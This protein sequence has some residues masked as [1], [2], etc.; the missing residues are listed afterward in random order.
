MHRSVGTTHT[1]PT[2]QSLQ[3]LI[4]T[5]LLG[6]HTN[7]RHEAVLVCSQGGQ[8]SDV[9]LAPSLLID[10]WHATAGPSRLINQW[11]VTAA[12]AGAHYARS[13]SPQRCT[14]YTGVIT[15]RNQVMNM[16]DLSDCIKPSRIL[17]NHSRQCHDIDTSFNQ[18][19]KT[20]NQ[21][22]QWVIQDQAAQLHPTNVPGKT[23]EPHAVHRSR[24]GRHAW[25][26][27]EVHT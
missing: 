13:F 11:H 4:L 5:G 7:N 21:L 10:Q 24:L 27:L 22:C 26:S 14:N 12:G 2:I 18:S 20:Q 9:L 3:T 1:L 25:H 6:A 19:I 8:M 16:S 15:I 23:S 17:I